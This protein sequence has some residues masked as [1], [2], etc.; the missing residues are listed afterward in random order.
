MVRDAARK[1][2]VTD[3]VLNTMFGVS[4]QRRMK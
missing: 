1:L 4:S 2:V 3:S